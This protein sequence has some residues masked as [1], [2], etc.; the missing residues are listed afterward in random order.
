MALSETIDVVADQFEA[1]WRLGQRPKIDV[2]LDQIASHERH[3]L[4]VELIRIEI[5]WRL[6]QGETPT[7]EEYLTSH[8]DLASCNEGV[9]EVE[10][11]FLSISSPTVATHSDRS[12]ND[13]KS[14]SASTLGQIAH[15]RLLGILGRGS[16]GTVYR[17]IDERLG[18][19]AAV[20][21]L[22]TTAASGPEERKRFYR[23]AQS[24]AKLRHEAIVSVYEAG[25]DDGIPFLAQELIS[26]STL[27]D[28]VR[29]RRL[30]FRQT[31]QLVST[32]A[33]A[34]DFAH[35]NG[36]IHR[37]I[38]PSNILID[39]EG[40]PHIADFGLA[41]TAALNAT[42]TADG[43]VVGTPS[44]MSPEQAAGH[45]EKIDER[46][47][48]Y[49]LGVVFYELLTGERPFRG[50]LHM[51]LQQVQFIEPRAPRM[52]DDRIPRDLEIICLKTL[53][54]S[55]A[56]R[57]ADA[58]LLAD[59][60]ERF[61][62][63]EPIMS[64]QTPAWRRGVRL[65]GR[66][67]RT[68]LPIAITLLLVAIG[69]IGALFTTFR[70]ANL[71]AM[72]AE[73][74][75]EQ[76][77]REVLIQ[78][79]NNLLLQNQTNGWFSRASIGLGQAAEI[80]RDEK[81][82]DTIVRFLHGY[83][84]YSKLILRGQSASHVTFDSAGE[85]LIVSG[86]DDKGFTLNLNTKTKQP[87]GLP[88]RGPVVCTAANRMLQLATSGRQ[89][90]TLYDLSNHREINSFELPLLDER[91]PAIEKL[92]PFP[93]STI[94]SN[95]KSIAGAVRLSSEEGWVVAWDA[96]EGTERGRWNIVAVSLALSPDG[97][98]L[99]IGDEHG[100]IYVGPVDQAEPPIRLDGGH[101]KI[102]AL[103]FHT[104][105]SRQ[106]VIDDH[107]E[108]I[109]N[110]WL[111]ASGDGG[112]NVIVW[113]PM[114]G[115]AVSRGHS[116]SFWITAL[117]FSPD[118]SLLAGGAHSEVRIWDVAKGQLLMIVHGVEGTSIQLVSDLAF[119]P[120]GD[121]LAIAS[122]K[123]FAD[124][125]IYVF[126]LENGRGIRTLTGLT[127]QLSKICFSDDDQFVAALSHHWEIGVWRTNDGTFLRKF[128]APP[129]YSTDNA[130]LAFSPDNLELAFSSLNQAC[131][132]D[133]GTGRIIGN[134]RLP[135]GLQDNLAFDSKGTMWLLRFET[136]PRDPSA[137]D[138]QLPP[139]NTA[140]PDEYRRV[141]RLRTLQP[142]NSIELVKE[143]H[144]W[145]VHI[146]QLVLAPDVSYFAGEGFRL[147][148][149]S[150]RQRW[151]GSIDVDSGEALKSQ[152]SRGILRHREGPHLLTSDDAGMMS[153]WRPGNRPASDVKS[154]QDVTA[155]GSC[156]R[157][158]IRLAQASP[159]DPIARQELF[160][161]ESGKS[162][163]ELAMTFS[164]FPEFTKDES[165]VAWGDAYGNLKL[166][167]LEEVRV[168]LNRYDLGW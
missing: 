135:P 7:L 33:R 136:Q 168:Q 61:L 27:E 68:A 22:N 40:K 160:D 130:A 154:I 9:R 49:S 133:L 166:A 65:L 106:L 124:A 30:D 162:L 159:L 86:Y 55:P 64:R 14:S 93:L 31:A 3:A 18:R 97:T 157:L 103:A 17:A 141:C 28:W 122:L 116:A 129:G 78:S 104:N 66:N 83:D 53:S 67:W 41:K 54:K 108:R 26:G 131:L 94:S 151:V 95:G 24:V 10:Q 76:L 132:W 42:M 5:S 101:N 149:D 88:Y 44:Y 71:R 62:R 77:Q 158:A 69:T 13:S 51:L 45:T 37:D 20:K 107:E 57:F 155:L 81:L 114:S 123:M 127:G 145:D 161:M 139:F 85:H 113:N 99:A 153:H 112:G 36:V 47:D 84:A 147:D 125:N 144:D 142:A 163:M 111:L 109:D 105:P 140:P 165:K 23:E 2:Y 150:V 34:L 102:T 167:D 90:L 82:R 91:E 15:F 80:R 126:D 100:Q 25:E 92:H 39:T 4:L 115:V 110:P 59:D 46:S 89:T 63:G 120:Q 70:E 72:F 29:T 74:E 11:F 148:D 79:L 138:P 50:E 98:W 143:F 164:A 52:L 6:R 87:G 128:A 43:Q 16:F 134:W 137:Q 58:S 35:R 117:A 96:E 8:A 156:Y 21:V 1:A 146:V 48:V 118:G 12:T 38:K 152:T 121:R 73:K 56:E 60:L 119:S 32:I 75:T 19:F